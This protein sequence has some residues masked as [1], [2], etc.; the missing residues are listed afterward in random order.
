MN[1]FLVYGLIAVVVVAALASF[2]YFTQRTSPQESRVPHWRI[3]SLAPSDT[4]I[5]ISLGLGKYIVGVDYY[6]YQLL[7]QINSTGLLSHNVTVLSQIS[8]PNVSGILALKPTLVVGEEGLLGSYVSDLQQAGLKVYLTNDDYAPNFS[9]IEASIKD[10]AS[11]F[12]R[13]GEASKL[14]AWMNSQ[15]SRFQARG[16]TTLAYI[17][18]I[19]PDHSFYTVGSGNFVNYLIQLAGGSN[20][21]YNYS[22]YPELQPDSLI[23]RNPQVIVAQEVYNLSYTQY[24][25]HDF[26]AANQLR[27]FSQGRVYI[28]SEDLPSSILNEPGPLSV[29]G[30][31]L[32]QDVMGGSA[33][34]YLNSTWVEEHL[35]VTLPVF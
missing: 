25:L 8:P 6:S 20:A 11:L 33:P 10:L 14:V 13:T 31:A 4:Q 3:V 17:L 35:N 24:L 29:Y 7:Q 30:V 23:V 22:G 34:Q 12:N 19:N 2:L 15:V 16:N 1:R 27:A 21:F 32:L 9:V 5:L 28:L 18:W 26:P